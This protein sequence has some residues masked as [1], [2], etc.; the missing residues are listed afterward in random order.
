MPLRPFDIA[1]CN[2][3]ILTHYQRELPSLFAP[4]ECLAFRTQDEM[5]HMLDRIL[6]HPADFNPIARAG[7]QRLLAQHTWSHRVE[8]L[9]NAAR[10]RLAWNG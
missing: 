10:Q 2:G 5:L 8:K 3:L 7:H 9:L 6:S 4:S 1:A